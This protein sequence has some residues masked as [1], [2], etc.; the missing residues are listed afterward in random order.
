M[1]EKDRYGFVIIKIILDS[2]E[3][4]LGAVENTVLRICERVKVVLLL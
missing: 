3:V 2:S 4:G 1:F